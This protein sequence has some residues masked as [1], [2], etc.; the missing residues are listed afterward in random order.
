MAAVDPFIHPIPRKIQSDPELRPFFEYFVRWAHD[1][2]KRSGGGDDLISD[3]DTAELFPWQLNQNEEQ[4]NVSFNAEKEE[5]EKEYCFNSQKEEPIIQYLFNQQFKEEPQYFSVSSNHTCY[6]SEIVEATSNI[7]I[8]LN[9]E[10][11]VGEIT[12]I[13]RNT[14]AGNVIIDGGSFNID[15][16]ATYTMALNY[17]GV[18]LLFNGSEY[19]LI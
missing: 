17:E 7:T 18:Q 19:L 14:T 16:A 4:T 3:A 8:T 13:K 11:E 15:G 2:W 5:P 12:K 6:G 9:Q 10:P 1:M